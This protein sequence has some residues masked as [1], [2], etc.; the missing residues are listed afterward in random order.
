MCFVNDVIYD[1]MVVA[2]GTKVQ[3][4]GLSVRIGID[5]IGE[6]QPCHLTFATSHYSHQPSAISH[7]QSAICYH[8]SDSQCGR[9]SAIYGGIEKVHLQPNYRPTLRL[10]MHSLQILLLNCHLKFSILWNKL[11][12]GQPKHRHLLRIV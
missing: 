4:L 1:W 8:I 2:S 10:H 5:C 6:L 3:R 7:P 12:I 9:E 11:G